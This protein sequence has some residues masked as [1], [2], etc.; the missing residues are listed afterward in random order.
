MNDE[1]EQTLEWIGLKDSTNIANICENFTTFDELSQLTASNISDLVDDFRRKPITSDKYAMPLII[2]KR[3]KFSIDWLLDF[4]WVNRVL[5]L[6][7]IYQDSF[8]SALKKSGKSAATIKKQKDKSDTI[9]REAAPGSL[10]G[11][12]DWT[13]GFWAFGPILLS[14]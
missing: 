11:K 5:T 12:K 14:F 7:G 1:I 2:Q 13:K 8:R 3:L 6:V 4:E 9:S 10:K